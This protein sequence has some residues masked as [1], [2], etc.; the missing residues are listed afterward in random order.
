[1]LDNRD[2]MCIRHCNKTFFSY[3]VLSQCPICSKSL[4]ENLDETPFTSFQNQTYLHIALTS[5]SG[6]IVEFGVN[7]LEKTP[8]VRTMASQNG[9]WDQCLII[10]QVPESWYD[11]WDEVLEKISSNQL[12]SEDMY[13][14]DAHNCYTFVLSFLKA[15]KYGEFAEFCHD[16]LSFSEKFVAPKTQNAAKYIT[17]HRK[18]RG[19]NYFSEEQ[20]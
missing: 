6:T 19:C 5:S 9:S 10:A 3:D 14:E 11:R 13:Q 18:L 12:W 20:E 16:K 4:G 8:P 1:M 2:L 7:G 15:L 17:I